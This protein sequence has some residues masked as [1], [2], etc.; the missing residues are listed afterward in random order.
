MSSRMWG[1][2]ANSSLPRYHRKR[3]VGP[4]FVLGLVVSSLD[5]R[6]VE[7]EAA[8]FLLARVI[9][10][11]SPLAPLASDSLTSHFHMLKVI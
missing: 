3:G 6:E 11:L 7:E 5:L 4:L 8:L 1:R 9:L 2:V 10:Q